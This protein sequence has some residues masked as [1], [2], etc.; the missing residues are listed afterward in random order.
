MYPPMTFVEVITFD[1]GYHIPAKSDTAMVEP[2]QITRSLA[3]QAAHII[4]HSGMPST[5]PRPV[6]CR[7]L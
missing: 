6:P 1:L 7:S 3:R 5:L 2:R 4:A